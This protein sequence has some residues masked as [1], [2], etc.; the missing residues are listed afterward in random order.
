MKSIEFYH[1]KNINIMEITS[2]LSNRKPNNILSACLKMEVLCAEIY[3]KLARMFPGMLFPG[4]NYLFTKLAD[5]EERH[6]FIVQLG[7]RFH[8]I[9]EMHDKVAP[10]I[11][12]QICAA[13]DFAED[14]KSYIK[15]EK[16]SL[17]KVLNMLIEM[18]ESIAEL[19]LHDLMR[20]KTDSRVLSYLQQFYKDEK[21]H[22][23]MIKDFVK[24][25][26]YHLH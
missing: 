12:D 20:I 2:E 21:Y 9:S 3:R 18:E 17:S 7:M 13:T 4:E 10:D 23:E 22:A 1:H 26:G 25:K 19:Y 16:I 8:F 15:P 6:A 14:I 24:E 11:M 5:S